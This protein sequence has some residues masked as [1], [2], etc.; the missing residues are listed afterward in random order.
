MLLGQHYE[1]I[2]GDPN[3]NMKENFYVNLEEAKAA[4]L[5]ARDHALLWTEEN[6]GEWR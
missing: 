6:G 5:R 2:T 1:S 4:L 3:G